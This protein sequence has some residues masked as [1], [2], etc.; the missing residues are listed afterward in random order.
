MLGFGRNSPRRSAI[1]EGRYG[2]EAR[3]TASDFPAHDLV[4]SLVIA[5]G[6]WLAVT[7]FLLL[8]KEV[9]AYRP[10]E[11]VPHDIVARV[12]FQFFDRAR[13]DQ[14]IEFKRESAFRAYRRVPGDPWE[15]IQNF[16]L[17]VPDTIH[18]RQPQELDPPLRDMLDNGAITELEQDRTGLDRQQYEDN[19]RHFISYARTHLLADNQPLVIIPQ[20]DRNQESNLAARFPGQTRQIKLLPPPADPQNPQ[21]ATGE[22]PTYIDIANVFG[23]ELSD[24]SFEGRLEESARGFGLVL[25]PKIARITRAELAANPNYQYDDQA[26]HEQQN[27]A[28]ATVSPL[29]AVESYVR[30]AKIVTGGSIL[31]DRDF[32][33]LLRENTAYQ[34]FL[35]NNVFRLWQ[36]RLGL[37]LVAGILTFILAAYVARYQRR[38]VRNH[39]RAAA[40][41]GLLLAMLLLTQLAGIGNKSLLI[42]GIAPTIV[43][44][45]ILTIAYDQRFAFGVATVHAI[46]VT[47]ALNQGLDWFLVLWVG[48]LSAC[49][50]LDEIRTRS[51]LIE[52]GGFAALAMIVATAA[53][54][55]VEMEPIQ[56]IASNCLYVGAAGL[57]AG[58]VVLGILPFIERAFRI[59][60]G[61]TLLELADASQPLLRRL[62][63]EAPGTYNHSLGVATLAEAAAESIKAN[64]LLCRVASYYHDVG[65]IH[66]PDYF[67]ENQMGGENRHLNLSPTLS[68]RI[69]Q[70]HVK[71]GVELAKEYHLPTSILPIIEQHHGTTVVEYFY[72]KAVRQGDQQ[73]DDSPPPSDVEFRYPGPKPRSKE[74]AIVM[75]CDIVESACRTL[76]EPTASRL[77]AKVQELAKLR[78]EDGQFEQCDLT[79]RDLDQIENAITK[80]LLGIYHGRIVYPSAEPAAPAAG[81]SATKTA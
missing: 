25:G 14:L 2:Y 6:F 48:V 46:I 69:I 34:A 29:D 63:L 76:A 61:M 66:K 78:L 26:T 47:A 65:K 64:S 3:S 59:T 54:G 40:M 39:A 10:G 9:V 1:R 49:Y 62:A 56:F 70:S 30:D 67:V 4:L 45:M 13:H 71:D 15:K 44:A 58:F 27:Q 42:F 52:V 74:A 51:K 12:D 55:A 16:L 22:P 50:L 57:A 73:P 53:I 37:A 33:L 36:N 5:A 38:C 79:L 75:L 72:S 20:S 11:Y 77:E 31:S 81:D 68:L 21:T 60:T 43:A 8:R 23:T 35:A 80:T 7:C 24:E 17:A 41:A 19:V 18:G 28:E 32:D